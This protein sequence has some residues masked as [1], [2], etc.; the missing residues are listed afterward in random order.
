MKRRKFLLFFCLKKM[1]HRG[2]RVS[3]IYNYYQN[4]FLY[5]NVKERKQEMKKRTTNQAFRVSN[6]ENQSK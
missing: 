6:N 2:T 3:Y 5:L 4:R 1:S